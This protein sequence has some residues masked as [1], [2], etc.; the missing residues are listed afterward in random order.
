MLVRKLLCWWWWVVSF[1][2]ERNEFWGPGFKSQNS[3]NY[4]SC[5]AVGC[6]IAIDA[7]LCHEPFYFFKGKFSKAF[8]HRPSI[9]TSWTAAGVNF[10]LHDFPLTQ[11][12]SSLILDP[13][14]AHRFDR[15]GR[16]IF[17]RAATPRPGIEPG[18]SAWQAEILTTILPRT[19]LKRVCEETN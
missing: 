6:I 1:W 12:T 13:E 5:F 2:W 10:Q 15:G 11:V 16:E 19:W 3:P 17:A 8:R 18:S 7:E 14:E 4:L 9:L